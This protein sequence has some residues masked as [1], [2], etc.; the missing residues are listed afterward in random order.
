MDMNIYHNK[1]ISENT[2]YRGVGEYY[3]P[4]EITTALLLKQSLYSYEP[5]KN[6]SV[7]D[8]DR[9]KITEAIYWLQAAA[10]NEYNADSFRQLYN[11][12]AAINENSIMPF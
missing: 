1:P 10:K 11:L 2:V 7:P 6:N 5:C 3:D 9:G 8:F 4:E 12:L